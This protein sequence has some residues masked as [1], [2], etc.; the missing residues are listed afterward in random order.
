VYCNGGKDEERIQKLKHR[1][2]GN[3]AVTPSEGQA[4]GGKKY[5]ILHNPY[6]T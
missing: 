3:A 5:V 1:T 4:W 2:D 6:E